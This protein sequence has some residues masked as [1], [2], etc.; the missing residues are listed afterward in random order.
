MS[1]YPLN[2]FLETTFWAF[3]GEG[4]RG[5]F[6]IIQARGGGHAVMTLAIMNGSD[7]A[8]E[9]GEQPAIP[10]LV[11]WLSVHL[12]NDL[13]DHAQD[14]FA[15]NAKMAYIY[16]VAALGHG[17]GDDRA[18]GRDHAQADHYVFDLAV[19][20]ALH[21]GRAGGHPAAECAVQK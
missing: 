10:V 17:A 6:W 1:E 19:N 20:V 15:A 2:R 21:S 11:G 13:R 16:A 12:H 18:A 4:Q 8:F 14:A 3:K 7:A 5:L 9:V